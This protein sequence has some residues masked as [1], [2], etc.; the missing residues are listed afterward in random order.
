MSYKYTVLQ[1]YPLSFYLLDE[2]RSGEV[3]N[4]T[5]LKNTYS[6][7]Q[8]LKDNGVSYAAISGLPIIDYS[9]NGSDGYAIQ[10]SPMNLIPI[11]NNGVRG[12]LIESTSNI[13][14]KGFGIATNKNPD[15]AFSVEAWFKPDPTDILEYPIVADSSNQIGIFYKN[16]NVVFKVD[17]LNYVNYKI[18]KN[19][20]IHAVGVF[21]KDKISLY[22]NGS[23]VKEK[24]FSNKF[25]FT[26]TIFSPAIGPSN[27]NKNFIIDGVAFYNYEIEESRVRSHYVS[28]Y[29]E[30]KYSQI[31]YPKNG[32][33]FSL[34]SVTIRPDV[35][36]RYP[37]IKN[38]EDLL[39][40]DTYYDSINNRIYFKESVGVESKTFSFTD[41]IYV[42]NPQNIQ[43]S[44]ISYGQ[45][46]KNILVE[47]QVPGQP[48]VACNNNSP[49]P[50][51]NKNQNLQ[52]SI[53]DIRV[54]MTT[55]DASFDLPYF[56][57][58]EIDMY[59]NKDFYS[60]NGG[61]RIYSAHDYSLG[62]Y[63]YPVKSQN[64]YNGLTMTDGRGFSVDTTNASR[65]I[66][67]FF[68]PNGTS[69]ILFSSNTSDFKW[70][71]LGVVQSSGISAVYVNGVNVT[72]STNISTF[73][74]TGLFHHVVL[75]LSSNSTNIKFNQNQAGTQYGL[76][77]TY[78]NIALYPS[79]FTQTEAIENYNLYCSNNI[80][81]VSDPGISLSE[82]VSGEDNTA[83]SVRYLDTQLV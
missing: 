21:S 23:L 51:Y 78:S 7:Y 50:Y 5:I 83:Y 22:L 38:F 66:E 9:G 29:K 3:T 80:Q 10:S 75:V 52:S 14:L 32:V 41:R 55:A 4:Y 53:L 8:D 45:D 59:S 27:I 49:L 15:S 62:N 33:F 56:D 57:K 25:K 67:L 58:L 72:S 24:T 69:N 77:N 26:N 39:T 17:A 48:W 13:K 76:N 6:T 30:R 11:I 31:V 68:K 60:D 73:F 37:G 42:S 16:E 36:Y 74:T 71:S 19:Q 2:V 18:S 40:D 47:V 82:S 12:T 43:S 28:G 35:S 34:N 44:T 46:V 1:D 64:S 70:T 79:A 63:N 61:S 54:T 20:V 81:A 65:T